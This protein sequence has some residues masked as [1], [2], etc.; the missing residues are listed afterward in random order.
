MQRPAR[1]PQSLD[2]S[3]DEQDVYWFELPTRENSSDTRL[4]SAPLYVAEVLR[5]ALY[6]KMRTIV[7]TSATLGI[8]G[9]L[10]YFLRRIGAGR[11]A[12]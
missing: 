11:H 6:D 1:N 5:D 2:P 8:R 3:E 12:R 4:F 10:I 7:F 9:K